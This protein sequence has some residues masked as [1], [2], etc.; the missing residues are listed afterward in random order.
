LPTVIEEV[1]GEGVAVRQ[2]DEVVVVPP[3]L[4]TVPEG[5]EPWRPSHS[6][7]RW[8]GGREEEVV[9]DSKRAHIGA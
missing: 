4:R 6:R 1:E 9:V 8:G 2:G 5:A 3:R 7:R